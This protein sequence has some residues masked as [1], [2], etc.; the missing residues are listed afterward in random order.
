MGLPEKRGNVM[1]QSFV[2]CNVMSVS[3]VLVFVCS[4]QLHLRL[5][6]VNVFFD[7]SLSVGFVLLSNIIE[8][9]QSLGC[10][11]F[12]MS[13]FCWRYRSVLSGKYK[14]LFTVTVQTFPCQEI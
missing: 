3:F 1:Y 2:L 14:N 11:V 12:C 9:K 13:S 10:N 4:D 8:L 6:L 7:D 5:L